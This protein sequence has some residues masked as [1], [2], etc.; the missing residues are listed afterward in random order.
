M[1]ITLM[2]VCHCA[3][4]VLRFSDEQQSSYEESEMAATVCASLSGAIERTV[5]ATIT[6]QDETATGFA[7]Q[8]C[9]LTVN[10]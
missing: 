3:E 5:V 10:E 7:T 6:T 1:H 8:S 4:V 2:L 9:T